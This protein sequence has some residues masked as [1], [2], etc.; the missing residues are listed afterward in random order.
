MASERVQS[1]VAT[2]DGP[3]KVMLLPG[4]FIVVRMNSL[5]CRLDLRSLALPLHDCLKLLRLLPCYLNLST[6][7]MSCTA[8]V[9]DVV[10]SFLNA[11]ESAVE[12]IQQLKVLGLL[13]LCLDAPHIDAFASVCCAAKSSLIGLALFGMKQDFVSASEECKLRIFEG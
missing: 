13:K 10:I 4:T 2:T 12:N 9:P 1:E 11:V 5:T 3:T 8:V 7:H 6:V